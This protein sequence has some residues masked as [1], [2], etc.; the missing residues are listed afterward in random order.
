MSETDDRKLDLASVFPAKGD[1]RRPPDWWGRALLYAVIAVYGAYFVWQSWG[2]VSTIVLDVVISMF[3]A[4]AVEPLV[5]SLVRH[6]WKRGVA[7]AVCLIGLVIIIVA[8]LALFGNMFVQQ[9]ISMVSGLPTLYTQIVEA[10]K[11]NFSVDMPRIESLGSE[12]M[13]YLQTSGA[14][15]ANQALTTTMG[16]FNFLLDLLTVMMVTYYISAAGPKMRRSLCQWLGPN[17]QRRFLLGWTVAQEQISGFLFSR[18]ILAAINA[19]CTG[20]FLEIIHVPYVLPLALFCGIVSQFIPTVG[21]YIG[22]ALPVLFAWGSNGIWYAAG[23]LVFIIVYQQVE[24]LILS[25]KISQRTMDL[26][27]CI[28]FLAVLVMGAV[29]GALGAFLALPV[30]ASLQAIFKV[31]T[32]R[33][34]LVESPLMSDP[35]PVKKSKVVES[36]EAF[37]EHVIKPVS[38]HMPRT[39]KGASRY[40][41]ISDE[42]RQLRDEIYEIDEPNGIDIE[43]STTVAIP[44]DVLSRNA[45]SSALAA[46]RHR[47]DGHGSAGTAHLSGVADEPEPDGRT[48]SAD[49][50]TSAHKT[51]SAADGETARETAAAKPTT[52]SATA[53]DSKPAPRKPAPDNPRSRWR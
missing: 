52:D 6:G 24:N 21:T 22:G 44:K 12:L 23:V 40:V 48:M 31:Y 13:K 2:K 8:L 1:P 5:L 26:N 25:P 35:V 30:T 39:V 49:E 50:T 16:V 41:P 46:R 29:F 17:T 11:E 45:K 10:V 7:S 28:A 37:S 53:D 43:E 32:K 19:L 38:D 36:A 4:L 15:L 42:L 34:E 9:L 14:G 47:H 20:I 3:I 51:T 27:P 18:S 33:Y